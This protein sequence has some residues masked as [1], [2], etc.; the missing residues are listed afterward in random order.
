VITM[1]WY[2]YGGDMNPLEAKRSAM[3][4]FAGQVIARMR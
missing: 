3:E 2:L 1:P 4:R